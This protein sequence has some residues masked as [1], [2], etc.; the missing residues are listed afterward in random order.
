[1]PTKQTG[2]KQ[3]KGTVNSGDGFVSVAYDSGRYSSIAKTLA[4]N[5]TTASCMIV[6]SCFGV[7]AVTNLIL[8][9]I[10]PWAAE[11]CFRQVAN[12]PPYNVSVAAAK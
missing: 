11:S 4:A 5:S 7:L 8:T 1:M 3:G 2:K 12:N 6:P 10:P 9:V